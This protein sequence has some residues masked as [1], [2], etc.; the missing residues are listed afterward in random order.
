MPFTKRAV[1]GSAL[2]HAEM[3]GNTDETIAQLAL[4]QLTSEKGQ[5]NG[6]AGLDGSGKV[7]SAQLPSFVDDVLEYANFA[8]LP[9]TG[10]AGKIYVL[11]TPYTSGGVTSSQFRWSGSAYAAIVASPGSTDAVTEGSTNLYFTALR[12]RSAVLTGL[13]TV[14]AAA[15]A[16]TDTV[17]QALQKLQAQIDGKLS[18]NLAT[19][20][21]NTK[22]LLVAADKFIAL[23]SAADDEP[24]LTTLA[25]LNNSLGRLAVG[26][27]LATTGSVNLD[28][29]ALANTTQVIAATGDITFTGSNYVS[30]AAIELKIEANGAGRTLAYPAEWKA[31]GAALPTSLASGKTLLI[32]LRSTSNTAASVD[33]GSVLSV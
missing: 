33:A 29:S 17:L 16:A 3:D 11:A 20:I 30:N 18:S 9:A 15:I 12:V 7:P 14:T 13:T 8:A 24:K 32:T 28:F 1:K 25:Q 23:D 4:R 2:S 27:S 31:Y 19:A 22:A 21:T 5:P 6:Y 26:T 10:E